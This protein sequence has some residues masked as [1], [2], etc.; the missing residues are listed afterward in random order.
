VEVGLT[1][2]GSIFAMAMLVVL[3]ELM[4]KVVFDLLRIFDNFCTF[5]PDLLHPKLPSVS[6]IPV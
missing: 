5:G 4:T 6:K 3:T 1:N 2:P